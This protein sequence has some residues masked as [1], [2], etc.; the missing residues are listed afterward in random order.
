MAKHL[1]NIPILLTSNQPKEQF[2]K[3]RGYEVEIW[4]DDQPRAIVG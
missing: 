4:I 3:D 1:P 2:A